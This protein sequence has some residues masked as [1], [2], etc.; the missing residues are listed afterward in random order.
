MPCVCFAVDRTNNIAFLIK[1]LPVRVCGRH[2]VV[3]QYPGSEWDLLDRI[4]ASGGNASES[5]RILGNPA[6]PC[7]S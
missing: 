2:E 1:R 4:S 3:F 6:N 7:E 5:L